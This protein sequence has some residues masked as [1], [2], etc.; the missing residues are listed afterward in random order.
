LFFA[1]HEILNLQEDVVG[2]FLVAQASS[3]WGLVL[4][5][6][7][8][9]RLEACATKNFT[10]ASLRYFC[11]C[12]LVVT[13]VLVC[14]AATGLRGAVR[15][16]LPGFLADRDCVLRRGFR[17]QVLGRLNGLLGL[18][19]RM[20]FLDRVNGTGHGPIT[21]S[22]YTSAGE[23]IPLAPAKIQKRRCLMG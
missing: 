12:E 15:K 7:K 16:R 17:L 14:A 9:H 2:R 10:A 8:T 13:A 4:A 3:L 22:L 18:R 6:T 11:N 1:Y 21:S 23:E 20:G 19:L 5:S